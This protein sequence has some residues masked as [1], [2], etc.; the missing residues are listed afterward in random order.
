MAMW[1]EYVNIARKVLVAHKFRSLLTVLS[2][3]VG[4]FS[5][6]LMSSLAQS[7]STTLL[8][9]LEELGGARLLAVFP[10][11]AEREE[12]K[13]SSYTRGLT[14]QDR[15]ALFE[16]VPHLE[17]HT[18]FSRL[19]RKDVIADNGRI[20]RID[21][22]AGDGD[23]FE[24]MG[25]AVGKGRFFSDEENTRHQKVC[26]IGHKTALRLF[27]GDAVGHTLQIGGLR[28]RI[29][30]QSNAREFL[31]NFF[32]LDRLDYLVAPFETMAD[33]DPKVRPSAHLQLKSDVQ[34]SNEIVKRVAN[35]ILS[36]RHHHVD[37]F[38]IFDFSGIMN[39]FTGFFRIMSII[40]GFIAGIALL[41]GGVGVMNMMLVSVS[42]RVREIGI[43]KAIGANPSDIGRQFL[44]EA[45]VLSGTGGLIGAGSGVAAAI[46]ASTL[47]RHFK[48]RWVT[49]IANDSVLIALAVS[50]GIGLLFGYFPARRASK[51]DAIT[52]IR[53]N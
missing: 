43:R 37:D 5:I 6:V 45:M 51:L 9:D 12:G 42:E 31:G 47:I 39:Q 32:G 15:D 40:V 38:Q 34:S 19:G 18:M 27:D 41:V 25:L 7:G 48:P 21:A 2:I 33:V 13:A 14:R 49:V 29:V 4:A 22:F 26:V 50:I 30:G 3:T 24:N 1:L 46:A 11:E 17:G 10:K 44:L 16:T 36:E 8:R 52:A 23:W 28:C 35:V 53:G 20:D